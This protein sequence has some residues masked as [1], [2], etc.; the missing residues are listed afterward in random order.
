MAAQQKQTSSPQNQFFTNTFGDA[1]KYLR[2]RAHLTQ[3]E[4]GR[5]VGYSREQIA[6]LEN[7]SRVPD[8]AVVAALFVPALD[9]QHQPELIQRLLELAG[10]IR[11]APGESQHITVAHTTQTKTQRIVEVVSQSAPLP[12]TLPS[13]LFP[14]IGRVS[15]VESLCALL[16]G[17]ARLITLIGTA[18]IGKTRLALETAHALTGNFSHGACFVELAPIQNAEA[19]PGAI[20]SALGITPTADQPIETA[21]A[22]HL[23]PHETLLVLDNC[24]HVLDAAVYFDK[25]LAVAPKLKLLCTSRTALDLYGEHEWEVSPLSLPILSQLPDPDQL[26]QIAAVQLFLARIRTFDSAFRLDSS[27]AV[28]IATLCV[29]LDGLPLALELAAA[30]VREIKPADLLH[31]IVSTR[32]RPQL[33]STLLQQ[34]KRNISARHRTLHEA[35]AWSYRLLSPAQQAAF[36]RLGVIVGGCTVEAAQNICDTDLPTL[37][38]LAS[39]SLIQLESNPSPGRVNMLET[40]RS[41]ALEQ[42]IH[43]NLLNTL[44]RKHAAHFAEY[45]GVIFKEIRGGQQSQWL[46]QTRLEHD[47]FRSALRF[48]VEEQD[49]HLAV[50]ISGGLWWFWYRQGFLSEG[51]EWLDKSLRIPMKHQP[52]ETQKRARATALNG[53]GSM[54]CEQCDYPSAMAYHKEGLALRYELEDG[55][56]IATVLHN[57]A[58]VARSQGDYPRAIELFEKS[59]TMEKETGSDS[60]LAMSYANIGITAGEM[61]DLPLAKSWLNRALE[62]VNV[63]ELPWE[64]AFI[65]LNLAQILY[66]QEDFTQAE[67]L[68][69]QSLRSFEEQ[70]DQLYGP[71][72]QLILAQTAIEHGDFSL[73]Q[74]LCGNVL[75]YY[76]GL[77]DEHGISNVLS[78]LAWITLH[79]DHNNEGAATAA[80]LFSESMFLREKNKRALSPME[81]IRNQM[82]EDAIHRLASQQPGSREAADKKE[83]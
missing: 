41:F 7:G 50:S 37:Q 55:E 30:R 2:K 14:L 62:K 27:N 66:W 81:K 34:T 8:L 28:S 15:E 74:S 45:A 76:Q 32:S 16:L 5:A 11:S 36:I 19:V 35:I 53:A 18:G 52:S 51:R 6:R 47:N 17:Q 60:S 29:A 73:A 58:L 40:L 13:P 49:S 79:E 59:L 12:Y 83:P 57:M 42:L 44:K 46:A 26:S 38:A 23:A 77:N 3:D 22:A 70:G 10:Q 31:Q 48:A 24:E 78:V 82:L 75:T 72:A 63:D 54:A 1:L 64:T 4:L 33:S 68:A 61:N 69:R 56:G 39:A 25:L 43:A 67:A 9:I 71:E 20:A 80:R 21:V 65:A